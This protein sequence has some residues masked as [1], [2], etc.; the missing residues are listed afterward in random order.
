MK[1]ASLADIKKEL[2][3][4]S[5]EELVELCLRLSRFKKE[6]K[7]LLTY[8][9][10]QSYNEAHYI[11][12]VKNYMDNQ[13]EQINTTSYFYMRKSARKILT[14]TK[15]YIRYSQTKETEVELLLYFCKKL[16]AL[17]PSI[18]YSTQLQNMYNRQVLLVKKMIATLHEDLQ[19]DYKLV[20][21][22]L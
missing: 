1:A 21:E 6:N 18:K 3:H 11:E 12:S 4:K 15:K 22:D 19:Y 10:F 5:Q 2:I 13:F 7:E 16:K 14:N 17:K 20:L 9:I 8:L